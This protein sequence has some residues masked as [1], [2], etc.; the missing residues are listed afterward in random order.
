MKQT[1]NLNEALTCRSTEPTILRKQIGST[2][3]TVSV[4]FNQAVKETLKEK[5]MR[6]IKND[7]Q[8]Q[9]KHGIMESLQAGWLPERSSL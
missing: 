1:H 7:L 6:V 4:H 3:Y 5:I 9:A 2:T 8:S